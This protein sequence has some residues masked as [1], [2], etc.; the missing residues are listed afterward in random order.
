MEQGTFLAW[1]KPEGAA[2]NIGEPLFELEGDKAAQE[3]E[4]LDAGILQIP[5]DAPKPGDTVAVGAVLG[6]LL[7]AGEAPPWEKPDKPAAPP[8]PQELDPGKQKPLPGS[9]RVGRP[10]SDRQT[11]SPR[12]R[13]MARELGIDF[14]QL[15]GS[16]R[17][18]RI[19]ERDVRAAAP[20][21]KTET[22]SGGRLL[23]LT[24]T[25]RLIAERA[26]L[27]THEAAPVTLSTR[28]DATNL[29]NLRNQFNALPSPSGE[30]VPGFTD[31]LIKI[32]AI[33]LREHPLLNASWRKDGIWL[34]EEIHVA[35]AVDTEAGLV[36][37]VLRDVP[38]LSLRQVAARS[39]E[40]M[41]L[42]RS[43]R[44]HPDQL[45]G[46]TFTVTN[47]G[48]H[49]VDGFT[50]LLNPPQC[51]ILGLGRIRPEAAVINGQVVP[52]ELVTLSLTFDHRVVDGAPAARFLDTVR[53]YVEQP[54]AC[55][56]S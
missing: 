38:A 20:G 52:R 32:A 45:Q 33:A 28:A 46:G 37:P 21:Q 16:G 8:I 56:V 49:N 22:H 11:I 47:L 24:P 12:A 4:S 7:A 53:R 31:F 35:I 51:A 50:P 15:K 41:E 14:K 18:G 23:P 26:L 43:R 19:R 30:A 13:R 36:A 54:G 25:R 5:P 48:M 39:R 1:L 9:T 40:L 6:Y 10:S 17:T 55:L 29:V 3:V 44:L 27:A 2:V 34:A 42:A